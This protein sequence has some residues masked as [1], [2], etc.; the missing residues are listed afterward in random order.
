MRLLQLVLNFDDLENK[1]TVYRYTFKHFDRN[2]KD[3]G[4][5]F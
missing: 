1:S 5:F 2:W 4:L 3:D